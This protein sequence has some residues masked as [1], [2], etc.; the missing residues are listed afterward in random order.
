FL[1]CVVVLPLWVAEAT[2]TPQ[3]RQVRGERRAGT[4]TVPH[5]APPEK[6]IEKLA[7]SVSCGYTKSSTHEAGYCCYCPSRQ[8]E[9]AQ[10]RGRRYIIRASLSRSSALP[11]SYSS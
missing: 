6:R 2:K 3:L 10:S 9:I 4:T 11:V 7:E 1:C 5:G 8:I